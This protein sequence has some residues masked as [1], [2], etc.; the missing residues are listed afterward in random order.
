MSDPTPELEAAARAA[1]EASRTGL[2]QFPWKDLDLYGRSS[3]AKEYW[4]ATTRVAIAAVLK[5]P[6]DTLLLT[7]LRGAGECMAP[8]E[9]IGAHELR[10]GFRAAGRHI[11]GELE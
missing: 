5:E 2:V 9:S 7:I 11:L 1:Y 6:S 8:G 4:Y 3:A 10:H